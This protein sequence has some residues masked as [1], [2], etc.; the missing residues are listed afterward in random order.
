MISLIERCVYKGAS[1]TNGSDCLYLK[2]P[3]NLEN[4]HGISV[5]QMT[6]AIFRLSHPQSIRFLITVL[7]AR[8]K[9]MEQ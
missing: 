5:S 8:I 9:L 3:L 2:P 7:V 4:R 1:S 6:K